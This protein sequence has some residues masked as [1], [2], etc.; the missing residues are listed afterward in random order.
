MVREAVKQLPME[1]LDVSAGKRFDTDGR[2]FG[3]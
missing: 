3:I 1:V 2:L